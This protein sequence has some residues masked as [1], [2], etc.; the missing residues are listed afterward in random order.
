METVTRDL[1]KVTQSVTSEAEA[2]L[3]EGTCC[4]RTPSP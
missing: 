3:G 1:A 2:V 4:L